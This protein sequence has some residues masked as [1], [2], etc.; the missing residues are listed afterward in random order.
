MTVN[1]KTF[2]LIVQNYRL[3]I[4]FII[5][6]CTLGLISAANKD[7]YFVIEFI[8]ILGDESY[9]NNKELSISPYLLIYTSSDKL[10]Q[11]GDI[12]LKYDEYNK[13]WI[14]TSA[15]PFS[16]K[17]LQEIFQKV[18]KQILDERLNL[19]EEI[20][21]LTNLEFKIYLENFLENIPSTDRVYIRNNLISHFN[22][23]TNSQKVT[24]VSNKIQNLKLK[25]IIQHIIIF[26]IIGFFVS[27]TFLLI[28][29]EINQLKKLIEK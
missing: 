3:I 1:N 24:I 27:I 17:D 19:H 16:E 20:I 12:S 4:K 7:N 26:L 10:K 23:T 15:E 8:P 22:G 9:F 18:K 13:I 29:N 2:L 21:K 25:K 14:A 5:I 11:K 28:R 6:F